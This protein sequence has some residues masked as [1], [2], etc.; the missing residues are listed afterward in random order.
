MRNYHTSSILKAIRPAFKSR[1]SRGGVRSFDKNF[2][3]SGAKKEIKIWDQK[4]ISKHEFF[5]RKYGNISPEE[6]KRLDEKVEKQRFLREQ[7]KRHERGDSYDRPRRETISLNPL[8]EYIFGTHSVIS[9]LTAGKREAFSTLYIHNIKEHTEKILGLAK[10]F[11]VRV[12]EKKSKGEL[13]TLSSNGVHNG[14]V[15]ETKPLILPEI[16][17]LTNNFDGISGSYEVSL[18]DD[19]TNG[20]IKRMNDI[21]RSAQSSSGNFPLGIYVDGVTDPQNLGNIVRS[22]YYL[23]ADFMVVPESE[24]ARLGPVTAK[25]AAGAL[26]LFTIYKTNSSLELIDSAK[27]NGWSIVSTSSRER[28]DDLGDMKSNHRRHVAGKYIDQN[29]LPRIMSAAP[30]LIVLGSEG[31][32]IRTNIKLRSDFLV[33]WKKGRLGQS[34]IDSMN[35]AVA[36]GLIIAKILE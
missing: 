25:A 24:T 21:V 31:A 34:S 8:C 18:I 14:V 7:R 22:A 13:N 23:G 1:D 9:A 33:G 35:V 16:A 28:E 6:R 2:D 36:A 4:G 10:K 19:A 30:M 20:E 3:A 5:I 17:S 29:E 32:G 27:K 15:L 26:D 12:V 11:G